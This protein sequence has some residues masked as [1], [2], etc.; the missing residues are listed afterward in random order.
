MNRKRTR[1]YIKKRFLWW[2]HWMGLKWW[3]VTLQFVDSLTPQNP[4]TELDTCLARTYASW[5]YLE[6]TVKVNLPE[7]TGRTKE[8]LERMI[9]HELSHILVNEMRYEGIEHEERVC[10]TLTK[11][12]IWV[13]DAS[14][15]SS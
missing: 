15:S 5:E 4:L 14:K 12:F 3:L 11:A 10:S 8:Q 13:R 1:K 7:A 2:L 9:V 6:A